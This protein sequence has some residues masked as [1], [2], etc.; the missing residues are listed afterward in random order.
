MAAQD[1]SATLPLLLLTGWAW[2]LMLLDA[3]IPAERKDLTAG[4][5]ALGTVGPLGALP[6]RFGQTTEAFGGM[7]VVDGFASFLDVVF[8]GS[9]LLGIALAY[10][11][12]KRMGLERG[13]YY[14]LLSFRSCGMMLM[15]RAADLIIVFLALELLSIP[16]YVL[17]GFA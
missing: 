15:G 13:E 14:T 9:G 5:A 4:L 12:L 10:D 3:F 1:L 17:S 16:L 2:A 7:L 11:Y 6:P 8:L